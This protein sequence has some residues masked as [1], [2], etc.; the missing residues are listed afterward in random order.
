MAVKKYGQVHRNVP[1]LAVTRQSSRQQSRRSIKISNES[2]FHQ[3][4]NVVATAYPSWGYVVIVLLIL[5]STSFIPIV[6][7]LRRFGFTTYQKSALKPG[8]DDVLPP[9][10]LT[11]TMSSVA[12]HL[13]EEPMAGTDADFDTKLE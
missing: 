1:N 12:L 8:R 3:Q 9:G 4:A 11:L 6:F 10:A 5:A 7:V 2:S 13:T